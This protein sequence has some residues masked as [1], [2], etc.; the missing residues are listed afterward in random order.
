MYCSKG[1]YDMKKITETD[2][3]NLIRNSQFPNPG[4]KRIL[5]EKLFR[6][7][8]ELDIDDLAKAAGGVS[9]PEQNMWETFCDAKEK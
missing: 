8:I 5:R 2:I 9:I 3:E 6:S 1:F 4:H 7:T